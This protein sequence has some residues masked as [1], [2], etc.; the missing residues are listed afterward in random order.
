MTSVPQVSV[1]VPCRNE[2]RHIGACLDSLLANDYP[3]TRLDV[4]VVDGM[5]DDGTRAAVERY[6]QA[7]PSVR[8]LDNPQRVT[9]AAL[10]LGIE[11]ARGSVII[12]AGAHAAYP[13]TYISE[14]V[15]WLQ[16]SGADAVGGRCVACPGVDKVMARA[17]A[18]AVSHPF[19]VGNSYFRTGT[20]APRW[21]DTVPFGCYWRDLFDRVGGFDEELVR[22]QDDEFNQRVLRYGGCLLLVPTIASQYYVRE[23]LGKLWRMFFQYGYFKPL[24]VR[25]V[26]GLMTLRQIIPALFVS[27]IVLAG[28][29]AP[30]FEIGRILFGL[31]LGVYLVADLVAAAA[32]ARRAGLR[33][34][35]AVCTVFPVL[36]FAYGLGYLLGVF[37][38]LIRGKH[39]TP[40]VS[41]SR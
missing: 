11:N 17:I 18:A 3:K 13:V 1:I 9:P 28:L 30:W 23:S 16:H 19:G 5:S 33:V 36:H 27:S 39:P 8:L 22:D 10:N 7:H 37:E 29:L 40:A 12:L 31:T 25:K 26:G 34:G 38:F 41:L 15:R 35:L 6:A 24:V 21:V 4:L 2:V 20:A 32:V 14:L